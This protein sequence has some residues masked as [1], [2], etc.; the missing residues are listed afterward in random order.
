GVNGCGFE[1]PLE[2]AY[3]ALQRATTPDEENY[4]FLRREADL[5]VV[6]VTDEVDCSYVPNQDSIFVDPDPNWSWEPGASS[7]TSAVCWN[8]GVQCDGDEPG[9]YTSC[10][11]VNRD[12]FGDV[13]AG[14]A[15]SVLHH[16]DRYS[17]QLQTI[18]GDKQQYGASVHFTA[19]AGVPEGYA[20]GQSEIAYLDDPDP[21]Q[22]ISF[23]IGPGCVD[24]LGGRG[25]P[26]VRIR[27]LHD[28]VGGPQLDSI[29]LASYDGAFTKMLGE[30]ISGL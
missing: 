4:G 25:L 14:P 3:L 29:C 28:A 13:G 16:L 26:P 24:G 21:A 7:A 12:L 23:G 18:I 11:A 5:L 8:A 27:E 9:P 22:Q 19:L 30:V 2:A 15:L 10:Y 17:E 1:A 6:L 20:D